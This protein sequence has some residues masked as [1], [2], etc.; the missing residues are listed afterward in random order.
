[1]YLSGSFLTQPSCLQSYYPK[2]AQKTNQPKAA[3]VSKEEQSLCFPQHAGA[4]SLNWQ[5]E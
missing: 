3:L 5:Q 4:P 1:M 2:V